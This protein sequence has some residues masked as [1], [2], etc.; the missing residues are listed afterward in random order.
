MDLP[1]LRLDLMVASSYVQLVDV[2]QN[3]H[4]VDFVDWT[5]GFGAEPVGSWLKARGLRDV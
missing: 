4:Q 2:G 3:T 1:G 5:A